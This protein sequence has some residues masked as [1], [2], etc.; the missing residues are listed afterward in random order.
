MSGPA[1]KEEKPNEI[2]LDRQLIIEILKTLEGLKR[3][4]QSCLKKE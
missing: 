3:V 2:M 1:A 4:L